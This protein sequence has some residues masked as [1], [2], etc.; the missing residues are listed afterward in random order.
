MASRKEF[1][2][3]LARIFSPPDPPEFLHLPGHYLVNSV[4]PSLSERTRAEGG[5]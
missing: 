3:A 1:V 4:V 2:I 5:G